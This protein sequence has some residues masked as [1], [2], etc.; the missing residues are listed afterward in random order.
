MS[1]SQTSK[2]SLNQVLSVT[3]TYRSGSL[4]ES[5]LQL[6]GTATGWAVLYAVGVYAAEQRSPWALLV[7]IAVAAFALPLF[8]MQH[9]CGHH[10]FFRSRA[11]NEWVGFVLGVITLTPH[12]AW[13]RCHALHHAGSGN[14]GRR[15]VG[16][17][18][19][20]T[21]EEYRRQTPWQRCLYRLYR[22]PLVLFGVGPIVLFAVRQRFA[23]Y[24]P[25]NWRRERLVTYATNLCL[26]AWFGAVVVFFGVNPYRF[27]AFHLG[28]MALAA[29]FGVWLFYVQ[30]QFP[31]T[32]WE[33]RHTWNA[34]DAALLGSSHYDLPQVLRW[35]T[36][37]IGL[38]HIHHLDCSIPNYALLRCFKDN[39]P[40]QQG[41]RL[42]FASSLACIRL[43]LWDQKSRLMVGFDGIL[44]SDA[45]QLPAAAGVEAEGGAL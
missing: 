32:Y 36:A 20:L 15:G 34:A 18:R 45:R 2:A 43:K 8:M 16:D 10:S 12:Q 35:I 40:L 19:T 39:P 25:T 22:N 30:H 37:D 9:D 21:V 44:E 6:G 7:G 38:H 1:P 3:R 11:Q 17:I 23:F 13:Y 26:L 29:S 27:L 31:D 5:L 14:L 33:E 41:P 24:L 42:T 28:S 4:S